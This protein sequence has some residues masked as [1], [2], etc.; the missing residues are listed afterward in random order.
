MQDIPHLTRGFYYFFFSLKVE[1]KVFTT[2]FWVWTAD[3]AIQCPWFNNERLLQTWPRRF[4][5]A[6]IFLG[7]AFAAL[8]SLIHS[9][10]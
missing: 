4:L 6:N 3:K 1:H 2:G 9:N 10:N 8:A 7:L 5:S